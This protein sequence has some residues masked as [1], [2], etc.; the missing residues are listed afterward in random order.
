[1]FSFICNAA[2]LPSNFLKIETF[3]P[4]AN[5]IKT[6]IVLEGRTWRF[7]MFGAGETSQNLKSLSVFEED[8]QV[9][10][11]EHIW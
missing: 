4:G 2:A 1:M 9:S 8:T 11:Q 7:R 10:L 5:L 6:P 3:I